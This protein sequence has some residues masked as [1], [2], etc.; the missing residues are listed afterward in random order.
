[1]LCLISEVMPRSCA[2]WVMRHFQ[3]A[4]LIVKLRKKKA[5]FCQLSATHP[6][7]KKT[8]CVEA[9]CI[10]PSCIGFLRGPKFHYSWL[11]HFINWDIATQQQVLCAPELLFNMVSILH[12]CNKLWTSSITKYLQMNFVFPTLEHFKWFRN[13]PF[14]LK[15]TRM[16]LCNKGVAPLR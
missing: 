2:I 9:L 3:W 10:Y 6:L 7:I 16:K 5:S 11:N 8:L 15:S 1:M 4:V 13:R 14:Y 12:W